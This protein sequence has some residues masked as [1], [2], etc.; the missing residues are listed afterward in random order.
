M[1]AVPVTLGYRVLKRFTTTSLSESATGLRAIVATDAPSELVVSADP[2]ASRAAAAMLARPGGSALDAALAAQLVLGLVEPQSSGLGGGAFLLYWDAQAKKLHAYDERDVA[3]AAVDAD[4][5]MRDGQPMTFP[6][7]MIGGRAVGVPGVVRLLEFAHAKHGHL[8]WRDA[9]V[10]A[11]RLARGGFRVSRR[12]ATLVAMDPVLPTL[13]GTRAAFGLSAGPPSAG[14][15]LTNR[16]YAATLELLRD[17]GRE[18][19]LHR[20]RGAD[21]ERAVRSADNRR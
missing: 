2:Q 10:E 19:V 6:R 7:A 21:I 14:S 1:L 20:A 15:R 4:L 5:F 13:A 9:F 18:R 3:P 17:Q 11:L 8:P 12:L 16:D